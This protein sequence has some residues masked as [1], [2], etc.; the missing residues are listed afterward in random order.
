M[1]KAD[2]FN[3][4]IAH[5]EHMLDMLHARD[6]SATEFAARCQALE[7]YLAANPLGPDLAKGLDEDRRNRLGLIVEKLNK[8]ALRARGKA[9][10]P[11]GLQK[12]IAEQQS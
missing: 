11:A 7:D 4:V 6:Q 2:Q 10:I 1:D 12:F 5:V 3:K 9:D 8:L